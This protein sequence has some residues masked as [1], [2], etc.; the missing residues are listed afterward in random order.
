MY[1]ITIEDGQNET[2]QLF[3]YRYENAKWKQRKLIEERINL[4]A[5]D[6]ADKIEFSNDNID[7]DDLQAILNLIIKCRYGHDQFKYVV[8]YNVV[9]MEDTPADIKFN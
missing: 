4:F 7:I 8:H 9:K 5:D 2:I 3:Y 1:C 6:E